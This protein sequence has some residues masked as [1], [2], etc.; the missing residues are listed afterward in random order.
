MTAVKERGKMISPTA[1][2]NALIDR[3]MNPADLAEELGAKRGTITH[4]LEGG[5]MPRLAMIKQTARILG[6]PESTL[7]TEVTEPQK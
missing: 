6:V 5:V 2:M 1:L 4:W 3:G 7:L